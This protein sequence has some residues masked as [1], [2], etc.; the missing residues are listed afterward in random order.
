ML[1]PPLFAVLH[2]P[3]LW[4]KHIL[5]TVNQYPIHWIPNVH[6]RHKGLKI[7]VSVRT[8]CYNE[9]VCQSQQ[10]MSCGACTHA[11]YRLI[12]QVHGCC[13]WQNQCPKSIFLLAANYGGRTV[14]A[15]PSAF[16]LRNGLLY[17]HGSSRL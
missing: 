6:K 13:S 3:M 9:L 4:Q 16:W 7:F 2:S 10:S 1:V 5:C 12:L 17:L 14:K 8:K 15:S 11:T